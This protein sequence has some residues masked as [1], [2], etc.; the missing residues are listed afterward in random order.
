MR[1]D[2]YIEMLEDKVS[3]LESQKVSK[4]MLFVVLW[5]LIWM[6]IAVIFYHNY[7]EEEIIGQKWEWLDYTCLWDSWCYYFDWRPRYEQCERID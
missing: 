7:D 2:Q 6:I 4:K 3:E 5:V 1:K